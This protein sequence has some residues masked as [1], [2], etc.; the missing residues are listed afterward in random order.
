MEISSVYI[1]YFLSGL[2]ALCLSTVQ[3]EFIS[4]I[5]QESQFSFQHLQFRHAEAG[6]A[7]HL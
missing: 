7:G 5:P 3:V 1:I 2:F 6:L 4:L